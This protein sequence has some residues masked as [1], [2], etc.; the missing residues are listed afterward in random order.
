MA[1]QAR[2]EATHPG[3]D[4][5]QSAFA[6]GADALWILDRDAKVTRGGIVCDDQPED[7]AGAICVQ[8]DVPGQYL[9]SLSSGVEVWAAGGKSYFAARVPVSQEGQ[10]GGFVV[11]AFR[12]SPGILDRLP[13]FQSQTGE[14]LQKHAA[15]A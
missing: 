10:A 5:L 2:S 4:F 9:R 13:A 8:A 11:A 6:K 7:R 3:T 15:L 12:R 14:N 1:L